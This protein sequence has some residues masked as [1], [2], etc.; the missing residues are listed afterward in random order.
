MSAFYLF[1]LNF[2]TITSDKHI[3]KIIKS[4]TIQNKFANYSAYL[5]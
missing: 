4:N 2:T 5:R 3:S 1:N